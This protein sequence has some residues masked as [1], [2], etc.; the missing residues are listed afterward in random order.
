MNLE[1]DLEFRDSI[2]KIKIKLNSEHKMKALDLIEQ[3]II[4]L[5]AAAKTLRDTNVSGE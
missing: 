5:K 4:I 1:N 3:G 2:K